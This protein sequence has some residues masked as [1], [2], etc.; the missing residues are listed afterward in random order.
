[1][2]DVSS[3]QLANHQKISHMQ[4]FMFQIS[5]TFNIFKILHVVNTTPS[6]ILSLCRAS[7][8]ARDLKFLPVVHSDKGEDL[9][10]L[11]TATDLIR[12]LQVSL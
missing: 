12:I 6:I 5:N 3:C 11:K 7:T 8:S 9:K 10:Y 2:C 4:W 1:M